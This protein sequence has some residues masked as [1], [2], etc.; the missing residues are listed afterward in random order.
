MTDLTLERIFDDPDLSGA[1]PQA[2]KFSP[3][4][5]YISFLKP[6][7]EDFE[8]L[9]IW[10]FET[11][12]GNSKLLVDS[13]KLKFNDR[14]LSDEEKA[15]RERKRIQHTGI[16]EYFWSPNSELILFPIS[17]CL[18]LY[19]LK[20][21]ELQQMTNADIFA[22]DIRFSPNGQ[23]LSY[24][25]KQNIYCINIALKKVLALTDD[26]GE[27]ITNG[28]AEFIAQ[29]EMHRFEAYWWAPD[30][31]KIAFTQ[32]DESPIEISQ[33]YEIEADSFGVFDQRY[34]YAGTPNATVRVGV[35]SVHES[36]TTT[37][38]VEW[39]NL[40]CD[41][42]SYICRV[43]WISDSQRVAVQVQSRNQQRLEL[44]IWQCGMDSL[45]QLAK[46][47]TTETSDSWLNLNDC[48]R[49][50]QDPNL[51]LW[52]SEQSGF[53]HLYL[54]SIDGKIEQQITHGDWVVQSIL[55]Y[56]E[57][58]SLIYFSGLKDT[59][60]ES[61][62]YSIELEVD[63]ESKVEPLCLSTLGFSH[64]LQ[65]DQN[66]R[67][68]IDRY[69]NPAQPPTVKLIRSDGTIEHEIYRNALDT[70]HPYSPYVARQGLIE[71]GTLDASD[72]QK[73]LYRL[74]QPSVSARHPEKKFP[75]IVVVYGGPGVQRIQ[76]EWIPPWY[77]YMTQRGYGILQLDNRGS[78]NRGVS[79]ESPIYQQLGD[80]EVEDQLTGVAYLKTLPWV[81]Q[82]RLGVFG[83][84]YG[85]YM[86]LM[87][88]MKSPETFRAGVSVAPVTDWQLYDTHYTERYLGLPAD[89]PDGYVNSNVF[90][91]VRGLSGQ[92]LVIHG[93][94]DDNVLFTNSTK[95]YKALQDQNIPFEIM[96]YPGAKH[97]LA[98]RKVNLHRYNLMD[99]FFDK[100][101][102]INK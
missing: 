59:P 15:V 21:S 65:P 20:N 31:S 58:Q 51:F 62:L 39:L 29:E 86:T 77:H 14:A 85:G 1:A 24:V 83:H 26:G 100:H 81:D 38:D 16:V 66:T 42:E 55:G 82:D 13:G 87:L 34:P 22:T 73:L 79:F 8:R 7:A 74:F 92:L 27:N 76:N 9:D 75:V 70:A 72:G 18:F 102:S 11:A 56:N 60:L 40:D 78:A 89:N 2:L 36:R 98:G 50:L 17:G 94:A 52:A 61:H 57:E 6:S 41:V 67:Y 53:N 48:F 54:K 10:A 12:T 35:I 91:Y 28:I 47:V 64:Q 43:N 5:K 3:D 97:G 93:M 25:S 45:N 33:R 71:N 80:V 44:K 95:L 37:P 4:S 46:T 84:S 99:R 19:S 68:F 30:S 101:L 96:N 32:T 90:P 49:S 23:F 69:S 88:M 63:S